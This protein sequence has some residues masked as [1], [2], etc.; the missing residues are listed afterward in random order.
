MI[1]LNFE[2]FFLSFLPAGKGV[3]FQLTCLS[4]NKF[5]NGG[6]SCGVWG[7]FEGILCQVFVGVGCLK[8][9]VWGWVHEGRFFK[10]L[11]DLLSSS[12][13]KINCALQKDYPFYCQ[14]VTMCLH[15]I[16]LKM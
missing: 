16:G 13:H 8:E 5:W 14:K 10:D 11:L 2:F 4:L 3:L 1:I 12:A 15:K 7:S 9:V 6:C